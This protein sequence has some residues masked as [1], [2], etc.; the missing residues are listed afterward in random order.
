[1]LKYKIGDIYQRYGQD[2]SLFIER[3][4]GLGL[5][6]AYNVHYYQVMAEKHLA[7]RS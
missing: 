2:W 6:Y 5:H 7:S 4:L 1:M 3:I